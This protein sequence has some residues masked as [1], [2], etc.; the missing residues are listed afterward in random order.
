MN[1][2]GKYVDQIRGVSY[3]PENV[4]SANDKHG[5][6]LLK[7]NNIQ[8]TLELDN[9]VYIKRDCVSEN[10]L[11]KTDDIIICASSGSK[12]L[13][14]KAI[15]I[16]KDMDATFGGFC[17]LIRCKGNVNPKYIGHFFRS[18]KY[19]KLISSLSVGSNINSIRNEHINDID[20]IIPSESIQNDVIKKLNAVL[21]LMSL[22]KK[23]LKQFDSLIKS[24]F[25]EMFGEIATN[26]KNWKSVTLSEAFTLQMGRTPARDKTEYWDRLDHKW[27]SIADISTYEKFVVD[28]KEKISDFAVSDCGMRCV[29]A[30]TVIMSFKLTIGKAAITVEPIFTNEAIMAFIDK[31]EYELCKEY[32]YAFTALMDWTKSMKKAVKGK[33]L[34]KGTLSDV[35]FPIPPIQLQN[36]F[37]EFVRQVDKS[38]FVIKNSLDK[39]KTLNEALMQKYFG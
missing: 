14:G 10:Q 32:I 16:D 21:L 1:K 30:D 29:P 28:T 24:Q 6:P 17:R 38:K 25:V 37:V 13:V 33:T 18:P 23:Q 15:Q 26:S 12:H 3:S 4:C 20:I 39:L 8:D 27:I 34:N 2:L 5:I 35:Q 19:R 31:K 9:L 7:A 22:R 36:Q 11:I